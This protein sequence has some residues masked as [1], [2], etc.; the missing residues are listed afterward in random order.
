ME[1]KYKLIIWHAIVAVL[2][3]QF[4]RYISFLFNSSTP[5]FE[6]AGT[7]YFIL[8]ASLIALGLIL[9]RQK[10]WALSLSSVNA[11]FYL[12]YFGFNLLNLLGAALLIAFMFLSRMHINTEINERT[13]VNS[14]VILRRGLMGIVIG[15]FVLISFAAYQ[16]P[17][18]KEIEKSQNLPLGTK[19]FIQSIVENTI[20]PQVK[21]GSETEK[22]N[23][24]TQITNETFGEMNAFLKP[25][26][27]Y[28]PPL[29]AFGLFLILWGLSWIFVQLSVLVGVLI[30][31]ILKK[32][33]MVK[34]EERDAKAEVL[35][36]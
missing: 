8:L 25:Y 14:R 21:T 5:K 3:W 23:I 27:Q 9:F 17:L 2:S 36:I 35:I 22:Q 10:K 28:A 15:T 4:W 1:L 24:I 34:I 11:L 33:D 7:V 20:G 12:V 18:A 32:S 13:K 26:F 19:L 30:F 16:S 29:L 31:L 6:P